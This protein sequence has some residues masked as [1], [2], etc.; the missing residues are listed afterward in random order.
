MA[1]KQ[2]LVKDAA[3]ALIMDIKE[4][5]GTDLREIQDFA[6]RIQ[7]AFELG[8]LS[9][10]PDAVTLFEARTKALLELT[11]ITAVQDKKEIILKSAITGFKVAR[12]IL[13]AL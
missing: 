2:R 6:T 4:S 7:E 12:T 5:V 9:G 8:L 10:D 3:L 13:L 11:R 1:D